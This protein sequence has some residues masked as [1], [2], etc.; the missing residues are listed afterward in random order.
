MC[1]KKYVKLVIKTLNNFHI[2]TLRTEDHIVL[3]YFLDPRW[4]VK[5]PSRWQ[6]LRPRNG[7]DIDSAY[8]VPV[9][10]YREQF[11]SGLISSTNC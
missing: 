6:I 3:A 9:V 2:L 4:T 10:V 8:C 7:L 5:M 1:K 11:Q